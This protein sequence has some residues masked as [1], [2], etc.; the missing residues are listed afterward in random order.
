MLKIPSTHDNYD[1]IAY[2]K[3]FCK[4]FF[5]LSRVEQLQ[6]REKSRAK[7]YVV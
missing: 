7:N 1:Y 4:S 2:F 3:A 6:K 5:N